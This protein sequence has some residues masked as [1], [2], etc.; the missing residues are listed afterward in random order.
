M[1]PP[2]Q[3]WRWEA[4]VLPVSSTASSAHVH[5]VRITRRAPSRET[6]LESRTALLEKPPGVVA[7]WQRLAARATSS[8]EGAGRT[9]PRSVRGR[10]DTDRFVESGRESDEEI[11]EGWA[12]SAVSSVGTRYE[13]SVRWHGMRQP[14]A[15]FFGADQDVKRGF[16]DRAR[17]LGCG[18]PTVVV[19]LAHESILR[20]ISALL[21]LLQ[22]NKFAFTT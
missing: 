6:G 12:K 8:R 21:H 4:G 22:N 13:R 14:R 19:V 20:L 17:P 7:R 5:R 1:R 9:S 2:C 3:T 11:V 18:G 16:S 10:H 15:G